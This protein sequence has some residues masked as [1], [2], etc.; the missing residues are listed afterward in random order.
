M[1]DVQRG[2][3]DP[4]TAARALAAR[5]QWTAVR[6]L[7]GR[8]SATGVRRPEL[9]TLHA[10]AELRTGRFRAA[11]TLLRD[12]VPA[13]I[14]LGNAPELRRAINMLGA[15]H[16]ELGNLAEAEAAFGQALELAAAA[17]A[18]LIVA[19]ATNNLGLIANT[20][21]NPGAALALYRLAIP[22]YQRVGHPRGLAETFHNMAISFRDLWQLVEADRQEQRAMEFAWEAEN[23]RLLAMASVGRAELSLLQ[24]EP[25]VAHAGALVA[26]E[27]YAAINDPVGEA[28][29]L[30]VAGAAG[31]ASG[32][33]EE[34]LPL[35]D[36]A[37]L[38]AHR[39]G[40]KL[41]EAESRRTRAELRVALGDRAAAET[42]VAHAATLFEKLGA[43]SELDALQRWWQEL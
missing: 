37:V 32:A 27:R 30:R 15:A 9:T 18:D 1:S 19:R 20:R 5:G 3:D 2:G 12:A 28:D 7:L 23:E 40:S 33:M 14:R 35:L 38:L 36:R 8:G 4:L 25:R 24:G 34:A 26:A 29:A 11:L 16:F 22:A 10:E 31:R 21:G 39:H 43:L 13:L 17:G 6:T 41:I 42:D